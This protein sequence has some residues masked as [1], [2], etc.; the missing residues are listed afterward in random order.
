MTIFPIKN[1]ILNIAV[2]LTLLAC[3]Q[4]SLRA[5]VQDSIPTAVENVATISLLT[6][7][8]GAELYS[9]FGHS[10]IRVQD[11]SKGID[12]V[13]NYGMFSFGT[14]NFYVKF[15][16]GKLP[17]WVSKGNFPR[18]MREYEREQRE[19]FQNELLLTSDEKKEVLAFL[20]NNIK[21]ENR[22]YAYDFF[23]DNCSSRIRDVLET[24]LGERL[25][26]SPKEEK[27]YTYR[28]LL[29]LYLLDSHWSDFGIDLILGKPTDE[30]A[31]VR[32]QMFLPDFL[33]LNFES[34]EVNRNGTWKPLVGPA[35]TLITF[36]LVASSTPLYK[37]PLGI[38]LVLLVLIAG[39]SFWQQN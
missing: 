19:V 32:Q 11:P 20:E 31:D 2:V 17:Y 30:N 7:A 10:A 38:L 6:C 3:I 1:F 14:P 8:P 37:R 5:Q 4:T 12:E 22:V 26:W 23:Y 16:K 33:K 27:D 18:F 35:T 28:N 21:K 36:P 13:Y 29:D 24:T 39:L 34:G 9:I 25:R 15:V